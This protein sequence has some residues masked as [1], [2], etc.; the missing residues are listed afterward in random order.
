MD[1]FSVSFGVALF[2]VLLHD[3]P[4]GN[5]FGSAAVAPGFLRALFYVFI[6]TLF[7]G[8]DPAKMLLS[9]HESSCLSMRVALHGVV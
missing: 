7:F 5:F 4:G 6:L 8:A 3:G 9:W 2:F 1:G